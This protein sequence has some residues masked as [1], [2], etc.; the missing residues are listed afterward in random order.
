MK[1]TVS[2]FTVWLAAGA[3]LAATGTTH[4][5]P[6]AAAATYQK[7]CG[8]C[9]LAYPADLLPS[10]SWQKLLATLSDHFGENAEL[11]TEDAQKLRDYLDAN[12][13]DRGDNR[14]GQRMLQGI[15]AQQTPLRISRL[16]YFMRK[17]DEVPER[18]SLGN[19]EVRSMS[20]CEACHTHA[21][22]GSFSER[23]IRI[24]GYR[25]W[26]D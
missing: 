17:H 13:A 6:E 10:R 14:R 12:A 1:A 7:E 4:A 2:G 22:E 23:E 19:P 15:A 3:M 26:E 18:M 11:A 21:R 25:D 8:A 9:H 5:Q 24:P 20:R 16:P